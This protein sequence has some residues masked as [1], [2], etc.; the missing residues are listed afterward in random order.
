[1]RPRGATLLGTAIALMT[2]TVAS[3]GLGFAFWVVAA[4]WFAPQAV[5]TISAGVASMALLGG[6][7]QL[8]LHSMYGRFLPKA[9]PHTARLLYAGHAVA[10]VTALS[11]AVGFLAIGMADGFLPERSGIRLLFTAGVLA[12]SIFLIQDGVLTALGR[13]RSVPL[14]NVVA[15]AAKLL[16]LPVFAGAAS[17]D[18]LL[19]AWTLPIITVM[20]AVNGWIMIRLVPAHSLLFASAT[21]VRPREVF[22][23]ASAEYV[24]GTLN[25]VIAF[26]PPLLVTGVLGAERGAYFY[27]P[28]VIGVSVTTLLWN[29]VSSFVV[30]VSGAAGPPPQPRGRHHLPPAGHAHRQVQRASTLV[31]A[32]AGGS[33]LVLTLGAGPMLAIFDGDY[34]RFGASSLRLIGLSLPFTGIFIL[35]GAFS[36]MEK[37][38]W[39]IVG[40]QVAGAAVFFA[41][42]A[43]G[44]P[45]VGIVAPALALLVSQAVIGL[46]VL[47]GLIDKYRAV[48]APGRAPSWAAPEPPPGGT[49][50]EPPPGGTPAEPTPGSHPLTNPP[51]AD[52]TVAGGEAGTATPDPGTEPI[53]RRDGP[54]PPAR[55]HST[56]PVTHPNHHPRPTTGLRPPGAL[57]LTTY[58]FAAPSAGESPAPRPP[59]PRSSVQHRGSRTTPW[60]ST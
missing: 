30:Q 26:L 7:A 28:W 29:V 39:R 49:P 35:Y 53:A 21:R 58:H 47:P 56:P 55:V 46:I 16:L 51:A 54:A 44:L 31:A 36:V 60:R 41:G 2:S 43:V 40:F 34:A 6:M 19:L 37:R 15:S 57:M 12:T 48:A 13:A 52:R 24:N 32:V 8:N 38:M 10:A 3:A 50:A 33:M 22:T 5:G 1:M 25:N 14:K 17:G 23:F 27:L 42:V 18:G 11:L 4:R 45:T 20:L 59:A 9:G